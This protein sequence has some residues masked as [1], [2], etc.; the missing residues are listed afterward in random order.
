MYLSFYHLVL[1]VGVSLMVL[2]AV[3]EL[4]FVS[5]SWVTLVQMSSTIA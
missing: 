5:F 1:H 4:G 3:P 2:F